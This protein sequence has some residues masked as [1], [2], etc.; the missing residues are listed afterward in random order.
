MKE[1]TFRSYYGA[2]LVPVLDKGNGT[3]SNVTHDWASASAALGGGLAVTIQRMSIRN[4]RVD[5]AKE[6][7]AEMAIANGCQFMMFLDDD[8][9]PP[10][11]A[12]M[13]MIN[14]WRSDP[15][16]KIISGVYWSKSPTSVPLIFKD[17][18]KGAFMDWRVG[19]LFEADGAGAGLLF[20]DTEILKQLP[21]PWFSCD[22]Y[23]D[24]PR[25]E[26]DVESWSLTDELGMHLQQEKPNQKRVEE[27]QKRLA[28]IGEEKKM[29]KRGV[30]D[31]KKFANRNRDYSS[32]E[33]LYFF[34]KAQEYLGHKVWIDTSI[35]AGHQD[36]STGRVWE[37]THGMPQANPRW[38]D[39]MEVGKATVVDIGAGSSEYW[40]HDGPRITVD[41]D[42]KHKPDILCDARSIPLDDCFADM[43]FASHILEHFGTKETISV[44]KEWTRI[45]KKDG[46]LVIVVPNLV[47]ASKRILENNANPAESGDPAIMSRA[48]FMYHSA[49]VGDLKASNVDI[50]KSGY[51]PTALLALLQQIPGLGDIEI[52]TSEGNYDTWDDEDKLRPD[53]DGYNIIA[54]AKKKRH[55]GPI[56]LSMGIQEQEEALQ[57]INKSDVIDVPTGKDRKKESTKKVAKVTKKKKDGKSGK[58]QV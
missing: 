46:K 20:I 47:W 45:L 51:T 1:G 32:T 10:T 41:N 5:I 25:G 19:D 18:L 11:D 36:K 26:L 56:S 42:P 12:L 14:L 24:D 43:V 58:K 22:Y 54:F 7:L 48:M 29:A 23:F 28:E 15:K 55:H 35:Q 38:G 34:K 40:I 37:L 31:P 57:H 39:K 30:V 44:L 6:R 13:K 2:V 3:I 8:V 49:Q 17:N 53:G 50:H 52:H 21:K 9:L 27:I 4:Y 16:Y 33:D